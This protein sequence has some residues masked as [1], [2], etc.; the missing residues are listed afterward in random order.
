MWIGEWQ[1]ENGSREKHRCRERAERAE[2]ENDGKSRC[3]TWPFSVK[4]P[5]LRTTCERKPRRRQH[6][7]RPK[8]DSYSKNSFKVTEEPVAQKGSSMKKM[9]SFSYSFSDSD[10]GGSRSAPDWLLA[11]LCILLPPLAVY[12]A[13]GIGTEFWI[14]ILLTLLFWI[15]GVIYAFVVIF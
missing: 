13:M 9:N 6:R 15:P 14:S 4:R 3:H 12:L 10:K 7:S 5:L 11:V 1:S 8:G 2:K